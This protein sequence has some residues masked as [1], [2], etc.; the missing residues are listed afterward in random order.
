MLFPS[1]MAAKFMEDVYDG[2]YEVIVTES[3]LH[4]YDNVMRRRAFHFDEEG[5]SSVSQWF[6]KN[7]VPTEYIQKGTNHCNIRIC[8]T[9]ICRPIA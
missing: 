1:G 7:S 9:F 5:I 2:Q 4:E 3:I 6:I 8:A